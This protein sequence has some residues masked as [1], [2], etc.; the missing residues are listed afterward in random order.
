[1]IDERRQ[2]LALASLTV[3]H[4]W[5]VYEPSLAITAPGISVQL[6]TAMARWHSATKGMPLLP[7]LAEGVLYLPDA[8][9]TAMH[10]RP[11]ST[12]DFMR[13]LVA[14]QEMSQ[15]L[16]EG[17]SRYQSQCL[18]HGDI[19]CDNWLR[20]QRETP[21]T[22]KVI[23]WEMSGAGD[24]A[25][26]VGSACAEAILEAIRGDANLQRG[27][28]GWP[29]V[30]E[31]VLLEFFRAYVAT[32]GLLTARDSKDWDRVVLFLIARLLHV[33]CELADYQVN[34]DNGLVAAVVEQARL[35]AR[36]RAK[37]T[38]TLTNW[39]SI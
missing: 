36:Q 35:F 19:R 31:S 9:E 24:P 29:L 10:E 23:D 21:A 15:M 2:I 11:R 13:S 5:P 14:D 37:L 12:Q 38:E 30:V 17:G 16:R 4:E 32:G 26:D 39:T 6:G 28:N 1:L 18:I 34:S 27:E 25:W 3:S 7:S 22:F 33:G 8:L 20:D